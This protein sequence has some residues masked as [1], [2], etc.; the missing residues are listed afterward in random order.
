MGRA[1]REHVVLNFSRETFGARLHDV[2][3]TMLEEDI[4]SAASGL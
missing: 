3:Y 4:G 1:A 2:L